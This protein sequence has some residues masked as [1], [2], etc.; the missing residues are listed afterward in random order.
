MTELE[1]LSLCA[2][3]VLIQPE[4]SAKKTIV[5]SNT[6]KEKGKIDLL[7]QEIS[8]EQGGLVK[9]QLS[10]PS[11]G[12]LK[13]LLD[14]EFNGQRICLNFDTLNC[15]P[16]FQIS[17]LSSIKI[18]GCSSVGYLDPWFAFP[19]LELPILC[20]IH[21]FW[22]RDPKENKEKPILE[23]MA[24]LPNRLD[25]KSSV[26]LFSPLKMDGPHKGRGRLLLSEHLTAFKGPWWMRFNGQ[27][28]PLSQTT[29]N[30][31]LNFKDVLIKDLW[32]AHEGRDMI[33]VLRLGY[34]KGGIENSWTVYQT[35]KGIFRWQDSG[36]VWQDHPPAQEVQKAPDCCDVHV[37][38]RLALDADSFFQIRLVGSEVT[39]KNMVVN[40][41]FFNENVTEN[42]MT[43]LTLGKWN[44]W[45]S[46]IK[47]VP[48]EFCS[49]SDEAWPHR[50]HVASSQFSSGSYSQSS[51]K[52]PTLSSDGPGPAY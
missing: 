48:K 42:I 24:Y 14:R 19:N 9:S 39:E 28:R 45:I 2:R 38:W 34:T 31:M 33:R 43:I 21:A 23:G 6:S 32:T 7:I 10:S 3:S 50:E 27:P 46:L 26:I 12:R 20:N 44:R 25:Q 29:K 51:S 1:E 8:W 13:S 37:Q 17:D 35:I 5:L 36:G 49:V 52:K 22:L 41:K 40:P 47:D 16:S 15:F 18:S 30:G 4:Q 11:G